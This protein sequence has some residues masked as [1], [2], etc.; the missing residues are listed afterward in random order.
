MTLGKACDIV[1]YLQF[2]LLETRNND[3]YTNVQSEVIGDSI[4][5]SELNV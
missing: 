2:V 1:E 3:A 4:A 5:C